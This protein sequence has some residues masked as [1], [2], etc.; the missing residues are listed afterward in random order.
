MSRNDATFDAMLQ[1]H[2]IFTD[3]RLR[4]AVHKDAAAIKELAEQSYGAGDEF[5]LDY[6]RDPSYERI[7][8]QDVRDKLACGVFL[9]G[10]EGEVDGI[11][12]CVYVATSSDSSLTEMSVLAVHPS[13]QG[14]R[15]SMRVLNAAFA[16]AHALGYTEVESD[17]LTCKPWLQRTYEGTGWRLT[18]E[19][20][21]WHRGVH[22]PCLRPAYRS[23]AH[24]MHKMMR[25]PTVP[26]HSGSAGGS[27][28]ASGTVPRR[29]AGMGPRASMGAGAAVRVNASHGTLA[30]QFWDNG[31][32][33][34]QDLF[35]ADEAAALA[36]VARR[37]ALADAGEAQDALHS[38]R[39]E[40]E[41]TAALARHN[42]IVDGADAD[43]RP[44]PRK[45]EAPL[46][47][48]DVGR[49]FGRFAGD[50]RLRSLI[51]AILSHGDCSAWCC[52][53]G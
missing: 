51:E 16:L 32:V 43:N 35:N 27:I 50:R 22:D 14:T 11:G 41:H 28:R 36:A 39:N 8:L 9:V 34:V 24:R 15:I 37:A 18:G 13:L 4:R 53:P 48:R 49:H 26:L 5:F 21:P 45:L 46:L 38:A 42:L 2:A 31:F 47:R 29:R 6:D 19:V 40:A 1:Q 10:M 52:I 25:H 7:S 3:L 17:V 12:T 23:M 30:E 44:L 20:R 33:V